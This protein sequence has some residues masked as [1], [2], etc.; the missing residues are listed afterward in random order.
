[1]DEEIKFVC[2]FECMMKIQVTGLYLFL[3]KFQYIVTEAGIID[4]RDFR[5]IVLYVD[6]CYTKT[7]G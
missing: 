2:S 1:M 5:S 4:I 7:K 6:K 3:C